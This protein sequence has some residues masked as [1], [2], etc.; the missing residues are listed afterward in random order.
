MI[1]VLNKKIE[2]K[3]LISLMCTVLLSF[4][5]GAGVMAYDNIYEHL[6]L[7]VS[8]GKKDGDGSFNNPFGSTEEARNY[9]RELKKNNEYP[10]NGVTV[11]IRE[12]VYELTKPIEFTQ[13]DAGTVDGDIVYRAYMDESVDFVG[14]LEIPIA[15][16]E[17]V[18]DENVLLRI[19]GIA[20]KAVRQYNLYE[21]GITRE[22]I[23]EMELSGVGA[24]SRGMFYSDFTET[25]SAKLFF[26][27]LEMT[28]ARW[29]NDGFANLGEVIDK[30]EIT[31]NWHDDR[32]GTP[33][34]VAPSDRPSY[35][36]G[37]TFKIPSDKAKLWSKA[38]DG[39][40]YGFF[41]YNWYDFS[42]NI[43]SI[44]VD[45]AT[46][47]TQRDCAYGA[48]AGQE[49]YVYN[50]LEELDRPG[51]TILTVIQVFCIFIRRHQ[52]VLAQCLS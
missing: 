31:R 15:D 12:G 9:I 45:N 1:K 6:S 24:S 11:N 23:G 34:Y 50:M 8:N 4:N 44:D 20:K 18:T 30:G 42:D 41:T 29:P 40:I 3:A 35:P 17:K 43:K 21:K 26:I 49:Y 7:Y 39:M 14:G 52:T 13:D 48:V 10:K 28:I 46:L 16:F 27:D 36:R 37:F 2:K 25:P 38:S 51:N 32:K 33:E 47:T 5:T 22:M 19:S